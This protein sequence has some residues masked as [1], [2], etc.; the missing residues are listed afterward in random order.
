MFSGRQAPNGTGV[1]MAAAGIL[2]CQE[3]EAADT[4]QTG[5]LP[6]FNLI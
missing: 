5:I 4:G 6:V 3:N 1:K 2:P